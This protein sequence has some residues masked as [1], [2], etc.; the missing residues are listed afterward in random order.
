MT[1]P[2][3]DT[4][5]R[6]PASDIAQRLAERAESLCRELLPTGHREG[7]EWRCGSVQGEPGNSLGVRLTGAK[8]G[9]WCDF[10]DD[11]KRDPLDLIQACLTLDKG[12]AVAWAKAWL[13]IGSGATAPLQPPPQPQHSKPPRGDNPNQARALDIWRSTRPAMG[14]PAEN[15]LRGRG[16]TGPIPHTIRYHPALLHPDTGIHLPTL[17]AAVCNVERKI[18]GI[19]RIFLTM[20]GRKAPLTRPKMALGTLRGGAVRLTKLR[21]L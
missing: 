4:H 21:Y 1:A 20:N 15:Y 17:V 19:T 7:A 16:I 12:Q 2:R 18:I 8:A 5:A 13:G 6:I 10:E 9:V 14:T 3:S 11:A